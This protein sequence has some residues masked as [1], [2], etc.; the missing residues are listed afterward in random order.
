MKETKHNRARKRQFTRSPD[1]PKT[2]CDIQ[3]FAFLC[4]LGPLLSRTYRDSRLG[5]RARNEF[6]LVFG[7]LHENLLVSFFLNDTFRQ[8]HSAREHVVAKS[9]YRPAN[10]SVE[11]VS[12]RAAW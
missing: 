12:Q 2:A 6:F 9:L 3:V 11:D 8:H 5:K 1:L 7:S 4:R 10:F